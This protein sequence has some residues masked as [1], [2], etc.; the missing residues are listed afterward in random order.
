MIMLFE[1]KAFAVVTKMLHT[2]NPQQ[3]VYTSSLGATKNFQ[4]YF[5]LVLELSPSTLNSLWAVLLPLNP[6]NRG[7]IYF[8]FGSNQEFSDLLYFDTRT[9]PQYIKLTLGSSPPPKPLK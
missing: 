5:I 6:P 7:V 9:I 1:P 2:L 8:K 3:G 4:I